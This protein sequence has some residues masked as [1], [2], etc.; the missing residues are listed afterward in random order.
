MKID[1]RR[2]LDVLA[3]ARHGSFSGA[4]EAT[5]VSQPAL[6]QSIALLERELGVRVMERGRHGARLNQAGDALVFHARALENLIERAEEEMRLRARGV[7]G[8]L[9]IGVTP[10]TTVGLVPQALDLLLGETPDVAVKVTE[11]LDDEI[12]A[13]L[14]TRELD[15]LVSRLGQG[16]LEGE[17]ESERLFFADWSLVVR[18]DHPLAE[19]EMISLRELRDLHWVLPAGGSAFRKQMEL[20]FEGAG[21]DWPIGGISTNSIL[22]IKAIVMST[23]CAT[24]IS[25]RLVAVEIAAGRLKAIA[26]G[27]VGP[28]KP[29]GLMWRRGEKLSPLAERFA[30]LMRRL[31]RDD[32]DPAF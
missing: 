16:S 22:A 30:N 6:S 2:L 18:P 31:A 29:V 19:R 27:D 3:V 17:V 28:L 7:L 15:L 11:G 8:P 12:L 26:L 13:M 25:Q 10:I 23:D 14:K 4:A 24:I 1:P 21:I 32:P 9:A 20:V 5:G